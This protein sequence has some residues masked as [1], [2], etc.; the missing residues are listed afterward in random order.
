M[1]AGPSGNLDGWSGPAGYL[2]KAIAANDGKAASFYLRE[3][4]DCVMDDGRAERLTADAAREGL[5]QHE[6]LLNLY[7]AR[8][9]G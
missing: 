4:C 3:L 5:A 1:H 2:Q 6:A 9:S 8:S 7:W